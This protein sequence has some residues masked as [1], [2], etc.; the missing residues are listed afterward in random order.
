M[1]SGGSS[2]GKDFSFG[3]EKGARKGPPIVWVGSIG[4][5]LFSEAVYEFPVES[6]SDFTKDSPLRGYDNRREDWPK[7]MHGE[8]CL[9]QMCAEGTYGGRRFFKCPRAWVML[10]TKGVLD[11]FNMY[12]MIYTIFCV[13]GIQCSRE[14]RVRTMGRSSPNSSS[15]GVHLLSAESYLRF[16]NGSKQWQQRRGAR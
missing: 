4:P 2:S 1:A 6:K 12:C 3:R 15:R 13:S 11:M 5:E 14:L 16:R 10:S 8:N 9:V 7:C